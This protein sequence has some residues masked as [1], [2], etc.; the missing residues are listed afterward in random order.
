MKILGTVGIRHIRA[1]DVRATIAE[2]A[3]RYLDAAASCRE[4]LVPPWEDLQ[5]GALPRQHELD[6]AEPG[7]KRHGWQFASQKVDCFLSGALWPG[8]SLPSRALLRS[9]RGPLG[10][11]PFTCFP[12]AAHSRFDTQPFRVL[13]LRRLWLPL[14]SSFAT[15]GVASHSI[16][17]ATTAQFVQWQWFWVAGAS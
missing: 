2:R 7:V 5:R 1:S 9:Q 11:L 14:P 10:G 13:L 17:V 12:T 4:R 15:A 6:D 16:P 8:L 3:R